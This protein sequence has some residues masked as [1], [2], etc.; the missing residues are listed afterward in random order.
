MKSCFSYYNNK[1]EQDFCMPPENRNRREMLAKATGLLQKQHIF[2]VLPE[3]YAFLRVPK[4]DEINEKQREKRLSKRL[5]MLKERTVFFQLNYQNKFRDL[6]TFTKIN[7]F[8]ITMMF[9]I[10]SVHVIYS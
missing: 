8:L 4:K 1:W 10:I 3:I 2:E 9:R 6:A 5:S 7:C